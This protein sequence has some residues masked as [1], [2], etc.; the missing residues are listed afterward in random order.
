MR[1][2]RACL[3]LRHEHCPVSGV[4]HFPAKPRKLVPNLICTR[5]VLRQPRSL[6]FLQ[7]LLRLVVGLSTLIRLGKGAEADERQHLRQS[8]RSPRHIP[9]TR[10]PHKLKHLSHGARGIEVIRKR[11]PKSFATGLGGGSGRASPLLL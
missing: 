6:P 9:P 11:I 4:P 8:L 2:G 1:D 7:K 10:F 3:A 5:E